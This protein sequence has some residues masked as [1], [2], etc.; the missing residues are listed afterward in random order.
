VRICI[1]SLEK[2]ANKR[3]MDMKHAEFHT[4]LKS[5]KKVFQKCTK[6]VISKNVMEICTFFSFTHVRQ[7]CF[8]YNFMLMH[9]TK[10]FVNGF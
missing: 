2:N 9:L 7:T 10:N 6:K 1:Q 3:K 4:D 5:V 8:A